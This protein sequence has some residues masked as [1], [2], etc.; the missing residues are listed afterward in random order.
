MSPD[1]QY[2]LDD[3]AVPAPDEWEEFRRDELEPIGIEDLKRLNLKEMP[4]DVSVWLMDD[5]FPETMLSRDGEFLVCE[6]QEHLYTKY[7]EHKF[8]AYVN[9]HIE[10]HWDIP[11][12]TSGEHH[13]R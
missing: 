11:E 8:S 7:W 4:E 10:S 12:Q 6:I 2:E 1:N 5:Y 3:E 13:D 9:T